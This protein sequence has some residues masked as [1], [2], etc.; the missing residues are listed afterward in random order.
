LLSDAADAA[1]L[2][3]SDGLTAAQLKFH[4]PRE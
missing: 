3:A 2:I 1:E 4:S